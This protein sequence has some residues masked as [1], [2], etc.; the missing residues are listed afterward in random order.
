[1]LLLKFKMKVKKCY[2]LL[3]IHWGWKTER[4]FLFIYNSGKKNYEIYN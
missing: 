1:L 2:I 3:Y 4:P